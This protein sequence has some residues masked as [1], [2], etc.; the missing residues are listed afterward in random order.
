M[1][2]WKRHS[3]WVCGVPRRHRK[4]RMIRTYDLSRPVPR[5]TIQRLVNNAVRAP[6]AGFS[7]AWGFW[8]S[9]NRKTSIDFDTW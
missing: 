5:N 7:Q 1:P 9:T 6:S 3:E 2:L 8:C 4:R